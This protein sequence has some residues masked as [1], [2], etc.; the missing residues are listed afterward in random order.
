MKGEILYPEESYALMGASFRVHTE[1]GSGF[2]EEVYPECLE[3][4]LRER[5]IPYVPQPELEIQYRGHVLRKG[6]RP[7]LICFGQIILELKA[8]DALCGEHRAQLINYLKASKMKL[9][10]LVNFGA[11]PKLEYEGLVWTEKQGASRASRLLA[12][13]WESVS[14]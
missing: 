13:E 2:A 4:E 12:G 3:L 10:L 11:F 1:L 8:L 9:G 7:D 14:V 5:R 6:F